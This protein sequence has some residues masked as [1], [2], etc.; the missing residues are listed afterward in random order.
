MLFVD[1]EI[2]Y[3]KI[4]GNCSSIPNPV[5]YILV[6]IKGNVCP[7]PPKKTMLRWCA[8][9]QMMVT[10]AILSFKGTVKSLFNGKETPI[11]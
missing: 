1:Q 4:R 9:I 6:E 3:F 10:H 7:P 11:L 8:R 2:K 5:S